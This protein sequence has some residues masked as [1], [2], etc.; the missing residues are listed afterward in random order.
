MPSLRDLAACGFAVA[1]LIGST[2][3]AAAQAT[4]RLEVAYQDHLLAAAPIARPRIVVA[5]MRAP[6]AG[7]GK[8]LLLMETPVEWSAGDALCVRTRSVDG[9]YWGE[10][11]AE[12]PA[13]PAGRIELALTSQFPDELAS[14]VRDGQIAA[15]IDHGTCAETP[16]DDADED[17]DE[18]FVAVGQWAGADPRPALVVLVNSGHAKFVT[19]RIEGAE[20][21]LTDVIDCVQV[22]TGQAFD[23]E[24][25]IDLRGVPA[26]EA[27]LVVERMRN[28]S[29]DDPVR[30]R[31]DLRPRP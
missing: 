4:A 10:G 23:A 12:V 17:G 20:G 8:P 25:R 11:S 6:L 3:A 21:R 5:V 29:P 14:A 13:D 26:E 28:T 15:R 18:P 22:R 1:L 2:S 16:D 19:A 31:L 9:R 30:L 7:D 27:T 24:C